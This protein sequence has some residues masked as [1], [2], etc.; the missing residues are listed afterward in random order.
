MRILFSAYAVSPLRGSEPGTS[1]RTVEALAARGHE[2]VVLTSDRLHD[3]MDDASTPEG[4]EVVRVSTRSTGLL[5]RG[6]VGVYSQY[7]RWQH[8]SARRAASLLLDRHFDVV[9]HFSWGSAP[10][11][12]PLSRLGRPFVFGPVGGGYRIPSELYTVLEWPDRWR[13]RVRDRSVRSGRFNPLTRGTAK[14]SA[15]ALAGDQR[16]ADLLRGAGA[17]RVEFMI[18]DITPPALLAAP[19][20]PRRGRRRRVLWVGR[21]LPRKGLRLAMRSIAAT[22]D[23]VTMSVVGE[24]PEREACLRLAHEL[25]IA[26]RVEFHGAVPWQRVVDELDACDVFLFSSL[27]DSFGAQLLEAAAR[28]RPIVGIDHQAVREWVPLTTGGRTPVADEAT[29]ARGLA[30]EVERLLDNDDDWSTASTASRRFAERHTAE[31]KAVALE[32]AYAELVPPQ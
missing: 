12:S 3:D 21:A 18:P 24:G 15:L 28:G 6:N 7:V 10:W 19:P 13:E 11:G 30:R 4:V 25:G 8:D 5:S 1:W 31:S 17:R 16:T 29:V 26:G 27:R 14:R 9:H 22:D 2:V 32:S 20:D 23:A